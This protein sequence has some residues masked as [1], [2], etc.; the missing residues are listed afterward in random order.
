MIIMQVAVTVRL[1]GNI[2]TLTT[3]PPLYIFD[4][5]CFFARLLMKTI[6]FLELLSLARCKKGHFFAPLQCH[7]KKSSLKSINIIMKALAY[8]T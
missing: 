3:L 1:K 2:V 5:Y 7:E 4:A 6:L 8:D